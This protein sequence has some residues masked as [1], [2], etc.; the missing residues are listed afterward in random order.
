[1]G[2]NSRFGIRAYLWHS[3]CI[4]PDRLMVGLRPLEASILVRIQ[5]WQQLKF[6][7]TPLSVRD[8][9]K[10]GDASEARDQ[11]L[12]ERHIV[13]LSNRYYQNGRCGAYYAK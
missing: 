12:G 6:I 5:V 11:T 13:P 2:A 8:R 3:L 4:L 9:S 7:F 1:M 10:K